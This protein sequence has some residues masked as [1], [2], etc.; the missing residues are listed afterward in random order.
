VVLPCCCG[1]TALLPPGASCC[2]AFLYGWLACAHR[3]FA[4][5]LQRQT[6]QRP[7]SL[8]CVMSC[9]CTTIHAPA[10]STARLCGSLERTWPL[11]R[12]PA[13]MPLTKSPTAGS[14]LE[15]SCQPVP[16]VSCIPAAAAAYSFACASMLVISFSLGAQCTPVY[17]NVNGPKVLGNKAWSG[18]L[19]LCFCSRERLAAA[20]ELQKVAAALEVSREKARQQAHKQI[21][22][23]C[24]R[25]CGF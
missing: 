19:S 17:L 8:Q 14:V 15:V 20:L 9:G 2:Q 11:H 22:H 7:C 4:P 18:L 10:Q 24:K 12:F 21:Q 23:A 13:V 1:S 5:P 16:Y 3:A 6:G 25:S